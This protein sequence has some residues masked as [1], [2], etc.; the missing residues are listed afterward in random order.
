MY[1][2]RAKPE[3]TFC[4]RRLP[5][6]RSANIPTVYTVD[7]RQEPCGKTPRLSLAG[8]AGWLGTEPRDESGAPGQAVRGV[9]VTTHQLCFCPIGIL[10]VA[11][12]RTLTLTLDRA[13]TL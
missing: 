7:T 1:T 8:V 4:V 2:F 10:E 3:C 11:K 12:L 9:R 13:V 5:R 6:L